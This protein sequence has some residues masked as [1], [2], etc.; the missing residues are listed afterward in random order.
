MKMKIYVCSTTLSCT[1]HRARLYR[2]VVRKKTLLKKKKSNHVW[3]LPNSMWQN[4]QTHGGEF[5]DQRETKIKLF[6]VGNAMCDTSHHLQNTFPTVKCSGGS[7]MLWG[8]F[9]SAG[10]KAL[11]QIK[12]M[13]DGNKYRVTV[14][15]NLFR[16]ARNLILGQR[17]TIQQTMTRNS[18][19]H[20]LK[21]AIH[22]HSPFNSMK[23]K[24]FCLKEQVK[25]PVAKCATI[26]KP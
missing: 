23:L 1:I 14:K 2:K 9:S 17:F 16:S 12:E 24:Q 22:Q 7:I 15:E 4:P 20:D 25:I 3:G 21:I 5:S 10:A 11:V 26:I 19:W 18:L 13:M 6:F 8:C